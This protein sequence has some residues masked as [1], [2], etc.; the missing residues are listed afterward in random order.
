MREILLKEIENP[1]VMET[2]AGFG[3]LY[4]R[5]YSHV[6]QGVAFEKDENKCAVLAIQRPT[7]SVYNNDSQQMLGAGVGL[8]IPVNFFDVDPYGDPWPTVD[9]ILTN[10]DRLQ[11]KFG[12]AVNDGL[13]RFIMLGRGWKCSVAEYIVRHGS[14]AAQKYPDICREIMIDKFGRAGVTLSKWAVH[15]SGHGGQMTN[16]VAVAERKKSPDRSR[17]AGVK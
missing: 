6:E 14:Q 1:I 2:H 5:L 12:L 16:Y 8:H 9:A 10:A 15:S 4:E 17:G 7:W 3:K 13:R 11:D